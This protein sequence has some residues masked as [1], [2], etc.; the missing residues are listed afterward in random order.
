MPLSSI[1]N[2]ILVGAVGGAAVLDD[3]QPARGDLLVHAVV[4]QDHAVGDVLLQAVAGQG[5]LAALAGDDGGDALVLEPA[6]QPAQ[7][8]AQ[9]GLV[10]QA[11]EERLDR[12]QHHALGADG[13]DRVPRR[14]NSP[15]RSYSPVSSIS[16]RS[17]WT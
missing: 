4:E 10:G 16:L 12:V 14:T 13:V 7:L 2:G 6:E 8:G 15:S 1:R 11:G 9:D 3:A 17:M 5:A